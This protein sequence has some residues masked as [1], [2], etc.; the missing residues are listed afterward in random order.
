MLSRGSATLYSSL[1]PP[2]KQKAWMP[3][4]VS[5]AVS[6]ATGVAPRAGETRRETHVCDVFTA[7]LYSLHSDLSV[8]NRQYP[9]GIARRARAAA[10]AAAAADQARMLRQR[11]RAAAAATDAAS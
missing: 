9:I 5:Q 6:Q 2:S 8:C 1:A 4:G 7:V 10:R 3:V 11:H